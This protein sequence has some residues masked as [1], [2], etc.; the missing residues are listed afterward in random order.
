MPSGLELARATDARNPQGMPKL[1]A[2]LSFFFKERAFLS[3]FAA[4]RACGFRHVE[5]M[6]PG[7]GGYMHSVAEVKAELNAHELTQVLL[8]SPAGDWGAG[9]RGIAG[10]ADREADFT[11]SIEKGL[12]YCDELGCR[13]MHVMA[14][15]VAAGAEEETL[16]RRLRWASGLAAPHG[17]TLL[18]EPLNPVDFPGYLVPDARTALRVL[19]AVDEPNCKLQLD[20]YHVAMAINAA[21]DGEEPGPASPPA[22]VQ[23][24]LRAMLPAM[25]RELLPHAAHVQLANPPGRNEPGVGDVDFERLLDMLDGELAYDGFVGCEY[26]PS[27]ERTEDSLVWARPWLA[28]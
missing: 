20:L 26:K 4:A 28:P 15:V 10:L 7:D 14:G 3:R 6:F 11:A 16:V 9:E 23:A 17:V 12:R 8:N 27:T 18:V 13:Q 22:M 2:N 1:A 24:M 25:L 21:A 19:G 5:F